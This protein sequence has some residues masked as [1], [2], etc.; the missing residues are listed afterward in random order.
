MEKRTLYV[1][2]LSLL[3]L[4]DDLKTHVT[5]T[6]YDSDN[7]MEGKIREFISILLH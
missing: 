2:R 1:H 6:V 7:A 5:R 3:D 4:Y